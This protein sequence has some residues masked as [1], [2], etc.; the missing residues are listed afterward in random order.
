MINKFKKSNRLKSLIRLVNKIKY[1]IQDAFYLP[2]ALISNLLKYKRMFKKETILVSGAD[3]NYFLYLI[4]LINNVLLFNYFNKIVIYDLGLTAEQTMKIN[5][6]RNVE[7]RKFDFNRYPNFLSNRDDLN[8]LG[9]YAW[10]PA[11]I[12]D[13]LLEFKTQVFWLDSANL[14]DKRFAFSRILLTKLGYFSTLSIG[15]I[16]EWSFPTVL[17]DL[18]VS[19]KIK[20]K[21]NLNGAI[22]AFD[23]NNKSFEL[24]KKWYE[25]SMKRELISP[26]N[27]SR[28]NHRYDQT[29]LSIVLYRDNKKYIPKIPGFYG[30]KIHQWSDRTVYIVD[31]YIDSNG[32][33]LNKEW[34]SKYGNI[35]TKTFKN[36]NEIIFFNINELNKFSKIKLKD[37]NIFLILE[38]SLDVETFNLI[39]NR[40]NNLNVNLFVNR[41]NEGLLDINKINHIFYDSLKIETLREFVTKK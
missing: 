39:K 4:E 19:K 28:D 33:S 29:L 35:S 12:Y 30:I 21:I 31:D 23:Y 8:K 36:A 32:L 24:A 37:K 17:E 40:F 16:N 22:I 11:I 41:S 38:N 25:Y 13:A 10:K 2:I 9:G 26:E 7:L 27:S 20:R 15:T 3:S 1:F 34:Y 6:I 18:K 14:I 5:S